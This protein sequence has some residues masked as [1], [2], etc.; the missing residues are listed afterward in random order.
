MGQVI[1]KII[2]KLED[3]NNSAILPNLI[4]NNSITISNLIK[5]STYIIN[6]KIIRK[7]MHLLDSLNFE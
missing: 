6:S 3:I 2:N 1:D 5:V 7:K 4:A